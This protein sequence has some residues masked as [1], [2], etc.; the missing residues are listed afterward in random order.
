MHDIIQA[1]QIFAACCKNKYT[2]ILT[3]SIFCYHWNAPLLLRPTIQKSST[4]TCC[5]VITYLNFTSSVKIYIFSLTGRWLNIYYRNLAE[6]AYL[7][8]RLKRDDPAQLP[9]CSIEISKHRLQGTVEI[10]LEV[11]QR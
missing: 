3:P 1:G 4:F 5:S 6:R 9:V 10:R 7:A 2:C 8:E 11:V